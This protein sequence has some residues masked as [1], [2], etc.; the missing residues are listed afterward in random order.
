M[1]EPRL[2]RANRA[3]PR[4]LLDHSAGPAPVV[5]IY[6]DLDPQ[7]YALPPGRETEITSVMNR[8]RAAAD[9]GMFGHDERKALEADLRRVE[10]Y[11]RGDGFPPKRAR[12]AALF[13]CEAKG[14]FDVFRL[15]NPTEA[16]VEIARAPAIEPLIEQIARHQWCVLLTDRSAGR[17]L[18]G[19]PDGLIER[20]NLDSQTHRQHSQGGWSQARYERS[21]EREVQM[22]VQTM[23]QRLIDTDRERAF[24]V[25][26]IGCPEEL[27][28]TLEAAMPEP[29]LRRV[30]GHVTVPVSFSNV[31]EVQEAL[32][33]VEQALTA[34]EERELLDRW[35]EG[36]ATHQRAV[37]GL[38]DVV[39]A[40]GDKRVEAVLGDADTPLPEHV[41][42]AAIEQD[43]DVVIV[44]HYGDLHEAGGIGAILRF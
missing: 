40:L 42:E 24:D 4:E 3:V 32:R 26:A 19:T 7:T 11:L 33:P 43:A 20:D 21:I 29:Y 10:D 36:V 5:S 16:H 27:W 28:P 41:V 18:T 1:A 8:A 23:V 22:H 6:L 34:R 13:V 37:A 31:E 30:A 44:R 38:P 17:I 25:L 35:A 2:R 12:A 14:L 39:S 15:P 9:E